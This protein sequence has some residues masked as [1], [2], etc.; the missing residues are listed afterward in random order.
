MIRIFGSVMISIL[1]HLS[2]VA[3]ES[4]SENESRTEQCNLISESGSL[5]DAIHNERQIRRVKTQDRRRK[6]RNHDRMTLKSNMLT[7][8]Y[9]SEMSPGE[10]RIRELL[11][12]GAQF[13]V[14][15]FLSVALKKL[16]SEKKYQYP[17]Y[18]DDYETP[19]E[20]AKKNYLFL[21]EILQQ[22]IPVIPPKESDEY[23][24]LRNTI[25]EKNKTLVIQKILDKDKSPSEEKISDFLFTFTILQAIVKSNPDDLKNTWAEFVIQQ[26][27]LNH[28]KIWELLDK[29]KLVLDKSIDPYL[30]EVKNIKNNAKPELVKKYR[31]LSPELLRQELCHLVKRIKLHKKTGISSF[32]EIKLIM[33]L[34]ADPNLPDAKGRIAKEIAEKSPLGNLSIAFLDRD[35]WRLFDMKNLKGNIKMALLA[36]GGVK[37]ELIDY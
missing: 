35:Y 36:D 5:V 11:F 6:T 24:N 27:A 37:I 26:K 13:G 23:N 20:V 34:G 8:F 7:Q 2:L 10:K 29:N 25:I 32:E 16:A 22:E 1:L 15:N 30:E 18:N 28:R 19:A 9:H 12:T 31:E 3:M 21:G 4:D 33:A 14:L 17:M